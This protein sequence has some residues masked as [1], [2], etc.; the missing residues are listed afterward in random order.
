M[1]LE[2]EAE[3]QD[4]DLKDISPQVLESIRQIGDQFAIEGEMINGKEISTGL[5]NSTYMAT[6]EHADGI[7]ARYVFQRINEKVFTDP[8]AVMQNI[9]CVTR[10]INWKVLRIRKDS[11]GRTLNLYP[12]RGGKCYAQ[13][14]GG[15]VWRCYNYIEGCRTYDV[16]E[17]TR[18]AYQAAFAFGSFQDLVSDLPVAEI[19]ETIKGF[20]HTPTRYRQLQNAIEIDALGRVSEV[21]A[22]L[23]FVE[24]RA[25]YIHKIVDAIAAGSLP[26]RITHNDTKINNVMIDIKTDKAVCVIDLDTVM[27]GSTLYDF[28]DMVRTATSPV[29]EDEVDLT[30]VTMQISMF[31]ALVEGYLDA[32]GGFL[33]RQE[34]ELLPFS[35]KLIAL[36]IGMRFLTDYLNGD[37]YF[38]IE[39]PQHNLDRARTQLKLI[40]SIEDQEDIM[41][42]FVRKCAN[43]L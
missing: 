5:I 42:R 14:P 25:H 37:H 28:G 34:I 11:A 21:R 38:K 9:E 18:Q 17:N 19:H 8:L 20:H 41:K 29:G 1:N 16:I 15:G 12:A 24:Q 31:E 22:E 27:P 7:Q 2:N 32:A 10:H 30:K 40:E 3:T 43:S 6:Y 13:G 26:I 35:G 36:E 4:V 23:A 39:R 33:T